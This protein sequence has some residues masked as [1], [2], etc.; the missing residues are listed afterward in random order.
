[1]KIQVGQRVDIPCNAQGS[2]P[3]VVTWL[4]SGRTVLID[5]VQHISSSDGTLSINKAALSD[6][7]IY[8][9]VASNIAGSDETK[10]ML[11]V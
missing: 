2:P 3:P 4:K 6:A 10:I 11:H 1:M 5:G 7:V 8:T 9:C